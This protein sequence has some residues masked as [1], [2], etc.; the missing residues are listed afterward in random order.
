MKT[1]KALIICSDVEKAINRVRDKRVAGDDDVPGNVL[2]LLGDVG[3]NIMPHLI[4]NIY[5]T[6][7]WG[8]DFTGV[9][10]TD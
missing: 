9:T 3:H 10:V 8:K 7:E 1:R 6:G 4:S 5:G 2:R